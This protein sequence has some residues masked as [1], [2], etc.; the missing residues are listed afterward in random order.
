[1][2]KDMYL[3]IDAFNQGVLAP[4]G[5]KRI[6]QGITQGVALGYEFAALSGRTDTYIHTQGAPKGQKL[7]AQGITLGIGPDLTFQDAP[8]GQKRI[9]QGI[10]LGKDSDLMVTPCKGKSHVRGPLL[11]PFQGATGLVDGTQGVAL[12]YE[13][14]ALSGRIH[15]NAFTYGLAALSGRYRGITERM[16]TNH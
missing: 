15:A 2:T 10:T 8:K 7:I 14:A 5:Q 6:A 4:K 9:A 12:G 3:Q 16:T 11:L 13:L 1:M